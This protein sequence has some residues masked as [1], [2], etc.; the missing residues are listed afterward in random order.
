MAEKLRGPEW[1]APLAQR[2]MKLSPALV[3][4]FAVLTA[5]I[6]SMLFMM[7]TEF[8]T[9][10][11]IDVVAKLTQTGTA[12]NGLIEGSVGVTISNT[13]TPGDLNLARSYAAN[14]EL[15]SRQL[16]PVARNLNDIERVGLNNVLRYG[17]LFNRLEAFTDEQID[18]LGQRLPD[19]RL[20][21]TAQL[22]A[23][24][25]LL[26]GLGQ[27]ERDA[28]NALIEQAAALTEMTADVRVQIEAS[29]PATASLS[30]ADL[31]G[32]MKLIRTN[33]LVKMQRLLEQVD[34]LAQQ[35][36]EANSSEADDLIA[37]AGL[38]SVR[39]REWASLAAQINAITAP[40]PINDLRALGEQLRIVKRLYDTGLVSAETVN[41]ALATEL[42]PMLAST[43]VILRPNN[44]VYIDRNPGILG[45]I[46]AEN[47]TP[48]DPSDDNRVD[49]VYLRLG[50]Q[51]LLFF[52]SNLENMIV[53]S[54][55]FIIAGLA[56]A[57]GFKAGL[58]NIGAEGQLYAGGILAAWVGFSPIFA[59]LPSWI[60]VPLC[61]IVGMTGG[62]LWGAI[63]GLLKAFTGAHEV[64][65]TIMLN[66][67]AIQLVDWLIK[68][69]NPVILLDTTSSV[70]RTPFIL[71][72]ARLPTFNAIPPIWFVLAGLFVAGVGLWLRRER[73]RT[74][75]TEAV[76]PAA[77]GILTVV[78]GLALAWVSTTG[79][80]HIGFVI[81]L[82]AVWFT[83]WF[84]DR[85]TPGFELRTVGANPDAAR[86]AGMSVRW[87]IMLA[88]ALS[89]TLAGL[90]GAVEIAGVHFNMTPGF[91]GGVGFDAIA[92]AL[93]ART[94]PRN[95]IAAGLLWGALL[96][97]AGLM[98][99]RAGISIDLVKIIQAL[100][101]M[102]IAADAIIR[103]LW[104]VP[105]PSTEEKERT[106]FA[107]KGW[108]G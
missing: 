101:I 77:Y 57:L 45:I 49:L 50:S 42:D 95:M 51:A 91:F 67:I 46:Y 59:G 64:I 10:G 41:D 108:G 52:P 83:G 6:V 96:S 27:L 53:R 79:K 11:R 22:E 74:A 31:L 3:P 62:F 66:F 47:K 17:A 87:N 5:L 107:A 56:V 14:T 104:R 98:Q 20:I 72:Q 76:R 92:V 80:I 68:S 85:T 23:V 55:P 100:I 81:M 9:T 78:L 13:L 38:E 65:N 24:R 35:G 15:T 69:T 29:I 84:L 40:A 36:I 103:F 48:D 70:P 73:L 106:L 26:E 2:W 99:S 37:I 28:A 71:G 21:G 44:Q 33:G 102:F 54:I 34:V 88:M 18:A 25:P 32:Q 58:F 19:I 39:V 94:N 93:L 60:H 4:L 97:G 1:L 7:L 82:A 90:A 8:L 75:P 12:Y 86:Y 61:I 105:E 43:Y 16:N 63:P 89:G 30:D